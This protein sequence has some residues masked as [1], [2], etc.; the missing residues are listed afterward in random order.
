MHLGFVGSLLDRILVQF[1][2][3]REMR[4]GLR[5]LKTFLER[6]AGRYELLEE[7]T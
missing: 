7:N 3:R 5:G 1:I 6:Q 4:A 2:V